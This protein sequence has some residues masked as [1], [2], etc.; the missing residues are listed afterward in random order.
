MLP[1][2]IEPSALPAPTMVCSSSI[3]RITCP[4]CLARSF[5]TAFMRSS[6]SPRN[7][8][9]AIND[10]ISSDSTR[11]FF[12]PSGTSPS[13]MRCARPSTNAVLPTPGSPIITGLF[14]RRRCSTWIARRISSSRPITGS[15]LPCSAR[16]VKSIVY[17]SSALRWSS[18]FGSFTGSEPCTSSMVFST[19]ARLAPYLMSNSANEFFLSS[20]AATTNTSDE[21]Y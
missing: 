9:P 21:M 18:A 17:F 4:S 15:I 20:S 7:F 5:S 13:T 19:A 8:A 1:A 11:L 2:S 10:P 12:M 6:K 16:S 3:N 14:F